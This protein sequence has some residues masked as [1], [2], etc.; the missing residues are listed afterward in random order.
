VGRTVLRE[1]DVRGG[2]EN[3][4][5]QDEIIALA[6]HPLDTHGE[7]RVKGGKLK[8]VDGPYGIPYTCLL[9]VEYDNLIVASRCASFSHIAASSCRLSRTMLALGEA[10]GVASALALARGVGYPDVDVEDARERLEI[11]AFT[12]KA[13][14]D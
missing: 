6:D 11:P 8:E 10:A 14:S 12:A 7:R 9:P 3:Q 2:L 1:Q 13:I 4:L 5:H